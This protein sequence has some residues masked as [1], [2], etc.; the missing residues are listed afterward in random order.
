MVDRLTEP[1]GGVLPDWLTEED[2]TYFAD[3]FTK[4]GYTGGLNWYR[5]FD[6]NWEISPVWAERKVEMP[7]MFLAGARDPVIAMVSPDGMKEWV[8]DL[9]ASVLVPGAG[10]WIQQE[11]PAET[12]AA[13]LDFLGGL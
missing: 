5:N 4:T 9:R 6:R 7:A 12:N 8:T 10:H 2:L 3:T 13:L 1:A 11:R